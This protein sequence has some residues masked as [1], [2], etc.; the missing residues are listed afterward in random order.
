MARCEKW[1]ELISAYIDGECSADER[2]DAET[3]LSQCP[4]CRE[5]YEQVTTDQELFTRALTGRRADMTDTVM[6][7]LDHMSAPTSERPKKKVT[8]RLV[9]L[10]VVVGIIAVLGALLF[11]VFARAREK[12]RQTS[13][14]SNVKQIVL[15]MQMFALDYDGRLPYASTWTG[16]LEPYLKDRSLYRDPAD[17]SD[18]EVSYS[19]VPRYSGA[20]LEDIP[21]PET[22]IIV[23]ESEFG[24]PAY[25]HNGGMNVGYADGHAKWIPE[26]P[27][28]TLEEGDT[29]GMIPGTQGRNFGLPRELKIA[30]DAACEIWVSRLQEAVV[31]AE[32]VFADHGGF[33]LTSSLHQRSEYG[34]EGSANIVGKV[35]VDRVADAVNA[36]GKLGYVA[37]REVAGEDITDSYISAGRSVTNAKSAIN[38]TQR[39]RSSAPR[40]ERRQIDKQL[41]TQKS[42]LGQAQDEAFSVKRE[43]Y[44][45]T[46]TVSLIQKAAKEAPRATGIAAAWE[47]F[48]SSAVRLGVLLVWAL[49]YG[50]LALPAMVGGYLV[51]RRVRR[52]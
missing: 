5:W 27:A 31:S 22:A 15:G 26:L 21:D 11:P 6:R 4:E 38:E 24:R 32:S 13:S 34:G 20:V 2:R 33:I 39:E 41:A 25:R 50:L 52:R 35:P 14:L 42:H 48:R 46:V 12:A 49:L 29:T 30:Y 47:S 9:E 16:Q 10:L 43:L 44:L 17:N 3:H 8:I 51:W 40:H 19:M 7:R 1:R 36:L 18:Q 45:S 28:G 23:Y 37:R